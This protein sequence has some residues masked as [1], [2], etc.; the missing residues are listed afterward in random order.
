LDRHSAVI[1]TV[2]HQAV[3][4]P[5]RLAKPRFV[6]SRA[7]EADAQSVRGGSTVRAAAASGSGS[8]AISQL[9]AGAAYSP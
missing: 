5:A 6:T 7:D 9:T 3:E 2:I 8:R 4:K 1:D